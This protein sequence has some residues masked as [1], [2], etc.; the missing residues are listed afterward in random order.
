MNII[1]IYPR[2]DE[3]EAT[4]ANSNSRIDA[5][6]TCISKGMSAARE[7][8]RLYAMSDAALRREG[9]TRKN[10]PTHLASLL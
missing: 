7:L 2:P 6:F 8:R 4:L 3:L 5:V 9:L 1:T 10:I